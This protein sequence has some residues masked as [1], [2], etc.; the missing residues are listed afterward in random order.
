MFQYFISLLWN[1]WTE[2]LT[3]NAHWSTHTHTLIWSQYIKPIKDQQEAYAGSVWRWLCLIATVMRGSGLMMKSIMGADRDQAE[4]TSWLY[5]TGHKNEII[6][7]SFSSYLSSLSS[8][9]LEKWCEALLCL[10]STGLWD[11]AKRLKR[12]IEVNIFTGT[13]WDFYKPTTQMKTKENMLTNNFWKIWN[14]K[15]A[16]G[17]VN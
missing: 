4:R 2:Y 1:S 12:V 13:H 17:G 7:Y 14:L 8:S 6:R 10:T 16:N 9:L 15:W 11:P 5:L 3:S